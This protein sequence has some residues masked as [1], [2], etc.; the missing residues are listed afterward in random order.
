MLASFR[1]SDLGYRATE[2]SRTSASGLIS[3]GGGRGGDSGFH[4]SGA[5]HV[6]IG[7][8]KALRRCCRTDRAPKSAAGA[9]PQGRKTLATAQ[10]DVE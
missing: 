2:A 9:L 5:E 8:G 3:V 7:V 1:R 4:R 6:G 10:S